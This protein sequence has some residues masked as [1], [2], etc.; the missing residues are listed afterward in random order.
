M[1]HA[2][3]TPLVLPD[4]PRDQTEPV[5]DEPWQATVFALAVSMAE[6]GCFTWVEWAA[7][8]SEEIAAARRRGDP[9]LGHTYYHHWLSALERLCIQQGLVAPVDMQQRKYDWHSAY[10][11]W[12]SPTAPNR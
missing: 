11:T 9:D 5:F 2:V 6:G 7:I 8:L 1:M 10:L 3:A 4:M 12:A